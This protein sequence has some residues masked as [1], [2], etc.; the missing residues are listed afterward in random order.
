MT[1]IKKTYTL[2]EA[3]EYLKREADTPDLSVDDIV[4]LAAEG[5]I[6]VC[7]PYRGKLGL[8]ENRRKSSEPATQQEISR[9]IWGAAQSTNYFHGL[10]RS[11]A[12]PTPNTEIEDLRGNVR[13]AHALLPVQVVP[14][15]VFA[16]D[17]PVQ[18]G[19]PAEHHWRRVHDLRA[20]DAS[21]LLVS[22]VPQAEWLIEAEGLHR[23][24][25]QIGKKRTSTVKQTPE[26]ASDSQAVGLRAGTH[27]RVVSTKLR[28]DALTPII[29]QAQH[30]C[31]DRYDVAAV[32]VQLCAM[33][34]RKEAPLVG[35]IE[36]GIQWSKHCDI[37]IF[38]YPALTERI[39]REKA[40][41]AK[42]DHAKPR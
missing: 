29:E 38:S 8:F 40:R 17:P 21:T 18:V 42:A 2:P 6:S 33:A 25:A 16:A 19:Q 13:R 41:H 23:H 20:P 7:F 24:A 31:I 15:T 4:M 39:R 10:L 36:D 28:R 37:V 27:S 32:W 26:V 14:I 34:R 1:S 12:P 11:V 30:K 9:E 5:V 22:T 35:V 3:V